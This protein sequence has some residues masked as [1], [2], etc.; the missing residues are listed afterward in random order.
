MPEYA[1]IYVLSKTRTPTAIIAFLDTFAA[2]REEAADEYEV[3]QY[4][5]SPKIVFRRAAELIDYCCV[6]PREVHSIYWRAMDGEKPEHAMVF[7]LSDEHVVYGVSTD[8]ADERL[9]HVFLARMKQHFGSEDALL[10]YE[11]CPPES[12]DAFR[13]QIRQKA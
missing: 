7:F 2:K 13:E 6:N 12:A 8:A 11:A 3:P 1:D 10:C 5:N 4:S 9:A